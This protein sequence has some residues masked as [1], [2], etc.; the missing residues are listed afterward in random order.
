MG[1]KRV[2]IR[3]QFLLESLQLSAIGGLTEI[4]L[5][6]LITS[7][8]ATGQGWLVDVPA[9]AMALGVAGSV[10]VGALAGLYPAVRA[11][12]MDPAEAVHPTV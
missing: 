3:S 1:A 11:A 10:V 12:R 4:G 7:A 9:E 6:A 5:G 2:H 8:H